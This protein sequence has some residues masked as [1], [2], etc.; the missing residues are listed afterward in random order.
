[1]IAGKRD[2]GPFTALVELL[3]VSSKR[4]DRDGIGLQP[5]QKQTQLQGELRMRW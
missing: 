2:F 5:R 1:M 4:D 3:H